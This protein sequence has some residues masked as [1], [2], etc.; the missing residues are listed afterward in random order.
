MNMCKAII[1]LILINLSIF[2]ILEN[3]Q[4]Q[5]K[6]VKTGNVYTVIDVIRR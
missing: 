6:D 4:I 3:I 1:L 5:F 2:M